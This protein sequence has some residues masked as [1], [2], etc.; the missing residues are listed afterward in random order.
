MGARY[1]D[2]AGQAGTPM[3]ASGDTSLFG[4]GRVDVTI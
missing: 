4:K 3:T 1:T 2:D